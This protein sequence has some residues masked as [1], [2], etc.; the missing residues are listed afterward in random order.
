[1]LMD[2]NI[3]RIEMNCITCGIGVTGA[4]MCESCW[5]KE[6]EKESSCPQ[7]GEMVIIGDFDEN[8]K[9]CRDCEFQ[10]RIEEDPDL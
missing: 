9:L 3:E 10:K 7:C 4:D 5:D 8:P 6:L 2:G 1:M